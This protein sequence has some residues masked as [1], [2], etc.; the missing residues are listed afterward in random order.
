MGRQSFYGQGAGRYP[1]AYNV[2]QDLMDIAG[3]KAGF[4]TDSFAPCETN[5]AGA[6]H[7][8]YVR[9]TAACPE[10]DAAAQE[11]WDGAVVTLPVSVAH[12]HALLPRLLEADPESFIAAV[13]GGG[14]DAEGC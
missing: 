14:R 11:D 12:M 4:Y 9:T 3:G 8:Y 2:V 13:Q 7:R 6:L 5:N 10:L 1:T